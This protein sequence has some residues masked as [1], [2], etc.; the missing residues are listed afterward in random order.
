[1]KERKRKTAVATHEEV[2]VP[3]KKKS[4]AGVEYKNYRKVVRS[5]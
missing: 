1:M 3:V 5:K 2:W 4:R